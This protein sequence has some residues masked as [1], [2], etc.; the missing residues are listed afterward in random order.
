MTI[1]DQRHLVLLQN[2]GSPVADGDGGFTQTW[3]D[4]APPTWYCS[5]TPAS[6]RD[7]ERIAAG[8]VIAEASH[9]VKGRYRADVTTKTRVVFNGRRLNVTAVANP[10]ERN[11]DLE[12]ICVEVVN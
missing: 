5:I 9:I 10:Q 8:T 1:G 7:L 2:P 4:L 12:L 11:V 3:A 6:T